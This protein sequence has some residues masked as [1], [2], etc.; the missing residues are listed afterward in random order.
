MIRSSF[1][2]KP[3]RGMEADFAFFTPSMPAG[4]TAV[5]TAPPPGVM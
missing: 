4:Q 1:M 5:T 2:G 3:Q